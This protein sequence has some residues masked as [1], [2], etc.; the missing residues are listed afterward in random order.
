[1]RSTGFQHF[2]L[3]NPIHTSSSQNNSVHTRSS[4][5]N[6]V[7]TGRKQDNAVHASRNQDVSHV[8]LSQGFPYLIHVVLGGWDGVDEELSQTEI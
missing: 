1:M 2:V 3:F 7:H 8:I 5:D 6:S 4:Q